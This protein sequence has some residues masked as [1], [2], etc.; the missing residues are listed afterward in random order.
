MKA[1]NPW[2]WGRTYGKRPKP[3]TEE[4]EV[5]PDAGDP[6]TDP[7]AGLG[8]DQTVAP[9]DTGAA[10]AGT[11]TVGAGETVDETEPTG[12]TTDTTNEETTAEV[13]TEPQEPATHPWTDATRH[14]DLDAAVP[15]GTTLPDGWEDMTLAE[16]KAWLDENAV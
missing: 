12:G 2:N 11:D 15:E 16:K 1:R 9:A 4:P 6:V 13:V 7:E 5:K 14:A 3:K 10:G 8:A